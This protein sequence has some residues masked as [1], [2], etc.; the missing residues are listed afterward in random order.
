MQPWFRILFVSLIMLGTW[1]AATILPNPQIDTSLTDVTPRTILTP[2]TEAAIRALQSNIESRVLLLISS[3]TEEKSAQAEDALRDALSHVPEIRLHPRND[4]LLFDLI[5]SM[6]PYRFSFLSASQRNRLKKLTAAEIAEQAQRDLIGISSSARLYSFGDDPFGWHGQALMN[7]LPVEAQDES[8]E[9]SYRTVGMSINRGAMDMTTQQ[10][11][12]SSIEGILCAVM[13]EYDVSIDRSGVFFFAADAAASARADIS[14]ISAV[15]TIGVVIL[16]LLAFGSFRALLLPVMSVLI[17][18]AFAA[19]ITHFIYGALHILTI[20]F[21][22]SLIG[23]AIDYALHYMVHRNLGAN[24]KLDSSPLHRALGLSLA[25]SIV[26][27]AALGLAGVTALQKVAVFSCAGLLMAWLTVICVGPMLESNRSTESRLLE[28]ISSQLSRAI[29]FIPRWCVLALPAGLILLAIWTLSEESSFSDDPRI[30]FN[31]S[32]ELLEGEKRVAAQANDYE[33]GRYVIITGTDS[34]QVY[35]RYQQ[36]I[37]LLA[38]QPQFSE[39]ALSSLPSWL[40]SQQQQAEDYALLKKLYSDNGAITNLVERL[41]VSS[42]LKDKIILEYQNSQG[43]LLTPA[44]LS[45]YLSE[46]LPPFWFENQDGS[47]VSFVLI[48]KGLNFDELANITDRLAGVEYVNSLQRTSQALNGQRHSAQRYLVI[49]ILLICGLLM[50]RY[51]A[52]RLGNLMLVPITAI[53]GFVTLCGALSI[54]IN[55]FHVMALF[56]VLGF[57]MD[58]VIFAFE[59]RANPLIALQAILLSAVTSLLSFGLLSVSEIPVVA[60]FGFALLVG[61]L[62][63]LLGA[64]L[65]S[66]QLTSR[67]K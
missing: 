44:K 43:L 60:S 11:L 14:L 19:T 9:I 5:D 63:N 34:K 47:V 32:V 42:T 40:P 15:S 30:F 8:S 17:G 37:D 41:G 21:G 1:L 54:P 49:A 22:A 6:K 62:I 26:G 16:L 27:Y 56:L 23:I 12:S 64:F 57:G 25:T 20:V 2:G 36:F 51:R 65:L 4:E 24:S 53:A 31:A 66:Q 28:L 45:A 33:P 67:T 18:V 7:L 50:L 38:S 10:T 3:S 48:R 39:S 59:M 35:T 13:N 61:N 52:W 46:A 29:T 55:L 58:Y